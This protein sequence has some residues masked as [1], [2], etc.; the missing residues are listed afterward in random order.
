MLQ[1]I[2]QDL[3]PYITTTINGSIRLKDLGALSASKIV[4]LSFVKVSVLQEK[5]VTF[6]LLP[7]FISKLYNHN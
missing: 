3:F 7:N 5:N 4:S 1:T 6:E 2:S